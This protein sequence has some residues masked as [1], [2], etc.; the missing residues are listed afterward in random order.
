MWRMDSSIDQQDDEDHGPHAQ[1]EE[2]ERDE[3]E[4]CVCL[5]HCS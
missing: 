2:E 4:L 5:G 3:D 1:K